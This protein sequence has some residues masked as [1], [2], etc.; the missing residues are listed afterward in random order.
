MNDDVVLRFDALTV[1]YGEKLVLDE[2]TLEVERGQVF[3]LLGRNG[4]GKTTAIRCLLGLG[5]PTSGRVSLFGEDCWK[6]RAHLMRRVGVVP[7]EPHAPPELTAAAIGRL[8]ASLSPGLDESAYRAHLDRAGVPA[9]LRF[10]SLS[11]GE[12]AHVGLALALAGRPEL[13]VLDDP[14]LGLDAIARRTFYTEVIEELAQRGVTVLI[15]THDLDAVERV[16]S[17]VAVLAQARIAVAG[18]LERLKREHA[19]SLDAIFAAVAGGL[20]EAA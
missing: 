6:H 17:H 15:A 2:I 13:L 11:R 4:A 20:R 9:G 14:T 10:A 12:K 19:P 16:A 3:A 1:R 5:R 8:A 18:E 7:E